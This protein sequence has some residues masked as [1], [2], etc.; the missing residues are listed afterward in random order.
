LNGAPVNVL[1]GQ[2]GQAVHILGCENLLHSMQRLAQSR[3][4]ASFAEWIGQIRR[5]RAEQGVATRM[6]RQDRQSRREQKMSPRSRF[7]FSSLAALRRPAPPF[8]ID[9]NKGLLGFVSQKA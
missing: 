8:G 9:E 2:G 1:S 7:S 4:E 5:S 6:A 3:F